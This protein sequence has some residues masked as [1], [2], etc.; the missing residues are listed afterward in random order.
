MKRH[1]LI[2]VAALICASG[3]FAA[4]SEARAIRVD[5]GNWKCSTVSLSDDWVTMTAGSGSLAATAT[6]EP[7]WSTSATSLCTPAYS[8]LNDFN[9]TAG[10]FIISKTGTTIYQWANDVQVADYT[11]DPSNADNQAGNDNGFGNLNSVNYGG[12]SEIQFN[13]L[14]GNGTTCLMPSSVPNQ[15]EFILGGKTYR[16]TQTTPSQLCAAD[17]TSDMLFNGTTLVGYI[18]QFGD[19]KSGLAPGWEVV[20]S[21]SAPEPDTLAMLLLGLALVGLAYWRSRITFR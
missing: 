2:A 19:V 4:P 13:Y 9:T 17:A 14:A 16:D 12:D 5:S 20:G 3:V 6:L 8:G 1:Q 21:T 7:G 15:P 10:P 11:L 18:D